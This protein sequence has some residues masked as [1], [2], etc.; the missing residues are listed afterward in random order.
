MCPSSLAGGQ[1][2]SSC[3]LWLSFCLR[4]VWGRA[5]CR[6]GRLRTVRLL[7]NPGQRRC[8][9]PRVPEQSSHCRP[10]SSVARSA[11]LA[12][13]L[14]PTHKL[15]FHRSCN[16]PSTKPLVLVGHG[17]GISMPVAVLARQKRAL[18]AGEAGPPPVGF[19][20][21]SNN[22]P[23]ASGE[24]GG[25]TT[26]TLGSGFRVGFN[27]QVQ[28]WVEPGFELGLN[29]R[30]N[31]GSNRVGFNPNPEAGV[32]GRVQPK[33]KP[34]AAA[35]VR[36]RV[37]LKPK[38]SNPGSS[39]P[40]VRV[41]VEHKP[42]PS[43]SFQDPHRTPPRLSACDVGQGHTENAFGETTKK[44]GTKSRPFKS[45]RKSQAKMLSSVP[46]QRKSGERHT[47]TPP[48][49]RRHQPRHVHVR[50][51]AWTSHRTRHT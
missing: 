51:G 5:T 13:H 22:P 37:E 7:Q 39:S 18:R 44:A 48:R 45:K 26:T 21:G 35:R 4:L 14:C 2:K 38:P 29:L 34:S 46:K 12:W 19:N 16:L 10:Q 11:C 33:P 47:K 28:T 32:R 40:G 15:A 41:W 25:T 23:P 49:K 9:R 20:L 6:A 42:K 1:T 17:Q 3:Q 8:F 31:S 43:P 30:F 50:R 24:G 36:V 27:P